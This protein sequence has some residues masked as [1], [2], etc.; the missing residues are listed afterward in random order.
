MKALIIIL[1]ACT[2]GACEQPELLTPNQVS[3]PILVDSIVGVV[4][5][6]TIIMRTYYTYHNGEPSQAFH[7]REVIGKPCDVAKYQ[8]NNVME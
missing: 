4:N 7:T 2:L 1:L 8:P 5:C 6:Q 3:K